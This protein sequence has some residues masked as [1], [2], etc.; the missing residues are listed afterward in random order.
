MSA[1]VLR[2][3]AKEFRLTENKIQADTGIAALL[4]ASVSV[5]A[6]KT[7]SDESANAYSVRFVG[8]C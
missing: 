2:R 6:L 5:I 8:V 1:A 3:R 4:V 7:K